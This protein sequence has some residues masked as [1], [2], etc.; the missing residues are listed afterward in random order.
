MQI[1]IWAVGKLTAGAEKSLIETYLKRC[2][3]LG[4]ALGWQ[5]FSVREFASIQALHA[6]LP[7]QAYVVACDERGLTPTSGEF[8][9]L[10]HNAP[11]HEACILLIGA[12][13]GLGDALRT[14]AQK[15]ISFGRMTLPHMLLRVVLAEQIYR[16]CTILNNHPYHRE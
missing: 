1:N 14:R 7:T 12:A 15:I 8:A 6:A 3:P 11:N 5:G 16:A 9:A 13:D 10:L 2:T 4:R